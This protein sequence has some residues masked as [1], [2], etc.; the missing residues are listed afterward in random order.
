MRKSSFLGLALG[1]SLAVGASAATATTD[2]DVKIYP[3]SMTTQLDAG[4]LVKGH[5]DDKPLEDQTL[6]RLSVWLIQRVNVRERLDIN[7]GVGG[8][9]FWAIPAGD[10]GDADGAH[11]TLTK[12]G[13]GIGRADMTYKWGALDKP[14]LTF[15]GGFFPYKYNPDAKDLGEYLLRSGTYPNTLETGGWNILSEASYMMMGARLNL[16]LWDGKFESDFLLP[17]E[18]DIPPTGDFSPTY[19][20]TVR[21]LPGVEIGGGVDCNHCLSVKPSLT[22]P[23]KYFGGTT[24]ANGN[25][26]NAYIIKN[27]DTTGPEYIR[28]STR[29]YTFKG[30]KLMGRASFDPKAYVPM[31]MLGPQDLKVFGEIALLGVKNY[32]FFYEKRTERMPVMWGI[33]LPTFRLVDILSF[34]MEYFNNPFPNSYNNQLSYQIPVPNMVDANGILTQDPN[35]YDPNAS[36]IRRDNWHWSVYTRKEIVHGIRLYGQVAN[37][38]LRVPGFDFKPSWTEITDRNGKDWYFLARLELGI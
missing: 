23:S 18:R 34:Q 17:M 5:V 6:S 29:Y 4:A 20:G 24:D 26:G 22:T 31:P 19:I 35:V 28:D 12:F 15:Q 11:K 13:P 33:N 14:L 9:F 10:I 27:P 21:P 7:V 1:A 36:A 8:I 25:P 37:D 2:P 32:P 30:V 16:S 3:T 38:H